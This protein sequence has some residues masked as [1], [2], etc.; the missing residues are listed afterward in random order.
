MLAPPLSVDVKEENPEAVGFIYI[1]GVFKQVFL[2]WMAR[3]APPLAV[4]EPARLEL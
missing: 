3:A 1:A 4:P 2:R